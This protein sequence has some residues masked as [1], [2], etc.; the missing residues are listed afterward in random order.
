MRKVKIKTISDEVLENFE[1]IIKS[2]SKDTIKTIKELERQNLVLSKRDEASKNDASESNRKA[3]KI[4]ITH[5]DCRLLAKRQY[6]HLE[7]LNINK[8]NEETLKKELRAAKIILEKVGYSTL[9]ER[10]QN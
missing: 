6:K 8:M 4:Y 2:F 3:L 1:E 10:L 7:R 9:D 5:K